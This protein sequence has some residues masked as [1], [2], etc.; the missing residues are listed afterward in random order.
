MLRPPLLALAVLLGCQTAPASPPAAYGAAALPA[1]D[2]TFAPTPP[3]RAEPFL[4]ALF[5]ESGWA[6]T[7]TLTPDLQTLYA[8]V[9]ERPD[10]PAAPETVQRLVTSRFVGGAWTP[11]AAVAETEGWRVDW[12]H[13]SPDGQTFWL[14][15]AKPHPGHTGATDPPRSD[16]FDLWRATRLP[17]APGGAARWTPLEP[18]GA[19]GV[20]RPKT[21]ANAR[22]GY[23]H[24]E[25]GPRVAPDGSLLFWT[26]RRDDGG[27]G[28]DLYLA[29]P[30]GA[31]GFGEPMLLPAPV[32][33]RWDESGGVFLADGRTL[34]FASNRPGGFGGSDLYAS[35]RRE[36]GTWTAPVNLGPD[37]NS[38]GAEGSPELLPGGG[39]L[40]FTSSR[41]RPGVALRPDVD[42]NRIPPYAPFWV[43]TAAV[44]LD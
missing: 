21:A 9:W 32:N 26:E 44:P 39:A 20:N 8:V 37:V 5:A 4:P 33:S 35:T 1:A 24:N 28:R 19:P 40:L 22:L 31:G 3:E 42:G 29:P 27:G 6:F 17:D 10:L 15:F 43:S 18:L 23:V 2:T 12:P 30:S 14:S 34:I 7:P 41:Q 36:D 11:L 16:D 25:T 38:S 13:V